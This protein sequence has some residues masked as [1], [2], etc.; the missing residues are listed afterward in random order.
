M[1]TKKERDDVLVDFERG[2]PP[3]YSTVVGILDSHDAA[4]ELLAAANAEIA[5][6][7]A[8]QLAA[9]E[10]A[11]AEVARCADWREQAIARV[12]EARG[13]ETPCT[14]CSGLGT[15]VYGSTSTWSGGIGGQAMTTSACDACWG[16]GDAHKTGANLR[17]MIVEREALRAELARR[18]GIVEKARSKPL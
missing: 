18:D 11:E 17:A 16:T 15:R 10:A 9:A 3:E 5:R 7:R 6:L 8:A 2:H 14:R 4:D 13:V 1:L 12:I